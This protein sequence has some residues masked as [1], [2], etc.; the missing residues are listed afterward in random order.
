MK[1]TPSDGG[2]DNVRGLPMNL[3]FK[4]RFFKRFFSLG[5]DL[6]TGAG[7]EGMTGNGGIEGFTTEGLGVRDAKILASFA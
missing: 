5:N 1:M 2:G 3:L 4:F 6:I 7:H